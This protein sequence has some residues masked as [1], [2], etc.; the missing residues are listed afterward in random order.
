MLQILLLILMTISCG[1]VV[2]HRDRRWQLSGLAVAYLAQF[3]LLFS[4]IPFLF[5]GILLILG[6]MSCAVIGTARVIEAKPEDTQIK[7]E[8]FFRLA[9]FLFFSLA[10]L[11]LAQRMLDWFPQID[12]YI[13][14]SSLIAIISGLLLTGFNSQVNRVIPGLLMV[15][16]GFES[17]YVSLELSLLVIGLMG[18]IKLG[19]AFI[20]SY[21]LVLTQ[22]GERE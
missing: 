16:I 2:A 22:E 3:F 20:S 17:I 15:L 14:A 1:L 11:A 13:A 21:W 4:H 18:A 19:L 9:T 5:A 7:T 6:S 8:R 10:A 12:F